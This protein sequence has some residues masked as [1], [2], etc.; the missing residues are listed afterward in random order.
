[1]TFTCFFFLGGGNGLALTGA[2]SLA[3]TFGPDGGVP[4]AVATLLKLPRTFGREHEYVTA[5]PGAID[6]NPGI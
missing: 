2:V 4:A 1:M 6:A 3:V 5:A